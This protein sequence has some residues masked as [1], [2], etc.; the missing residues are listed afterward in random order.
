[1]RIVLYGSSDHPAFFSEVIKQ[2]REFLL[3]DWWA[4]IP[5]YHF[6]EEFKEM[7]GE[8]R[9][10]YLQGRLK[11]EMNKPTPHL[12]ILRG[13]VGSVYA[14]LVA[15]MHSIEAYPKDYQLKHT[16]CIYQLFKRF[17]QKAKPDVLLLPLLDTHESMVLYKLCKEM[18]IPIIIPSHSRNLGRSFFSDSYEEDLPSYAFGKISLKS[19]LEA[20]SFIH[21][22]RLAHK[23]PLRSNAYAPREDEII[24]YPKRS[25]WNRTS[26]YLKNKLMNTEPHFVNE[27]KI[28]VVL[29]YTPLFSILNKIRWMF[30]ERLFEIHSLGLLPKRFIYYP[31]QYTPESSINIPAPFFVDQLRAIDM[32]RLNMPSDC[33]L[34]VKEHPAM[35]GRRSS[36]FYR[37]LK[38]KTGVMLAHPKLSSRKLIERALITVSVTGT[39]C[40][41][42]FL[43]GLP[44]FHI[45]KAFF[46]NW[47]THCDCADM[48]GMLY[49]AIKNKPNEKKILDLVS[50]VYEASYDFVCYGPGDKI[51]G[52]QYLMNTWNVRAFLFAMVDHIKKMG[53][54]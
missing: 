54:V 14:D 46:T 42:A 28:Y 44:S 43:L 53:V 1:M 34:V 20:R 3:I 49:K 6:L 40:L 50:R 8:E 33:Y 31:L 39:A 9:V 51:L 47:I 15:N 22:F 23:E 10:L 27:L 16:M 25:F 11:D 18:G 5:T 13:Y 12:S 2:S 21:N 26:R 32:I 17:L 45:G 35:I 7:L 19:K 48:R 4:I 41:E 37:E 52:S 30:S 29:E 36:C 24:P 38:K